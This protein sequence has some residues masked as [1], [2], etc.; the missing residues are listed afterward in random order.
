MSRGMKLMVAGFTL[1]LIGGGLL[2]LAAT[3]GHAVS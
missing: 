1:M 2:A 3:A